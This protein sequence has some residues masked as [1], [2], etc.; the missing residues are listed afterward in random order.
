MYMPGVAYGIGTKLG[1]D[2]L[3]KKYDCTDGTIGKTG[4][5]VGDF[6]LSLFE[7]SEIPAIKPRVLI[8]TVTKPGFGLKE[9]RDK[10]EFEDAQG[11][12]LTPASNVIAEDMMFGTSFD[13]ST[14][15]D[16]KV[17]ENIERLS[18]N[19]M[20]NCSRT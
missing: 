20:M 6:I 12:G 16:A 3:N 9:D 2:R 15:K 1:K 7:Q 17:R 19:L 4:N 18:K 10:Y 5:G 13:L 14:I 8:Q 11:K